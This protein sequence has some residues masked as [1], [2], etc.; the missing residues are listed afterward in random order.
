MKSVESRRKNTLGDRG[1]ALGSLMNL[2]RANIPTRGGN[3]NGSGTAPQPAV[4]RGADL[5]TLER[6]G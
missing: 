4:G 6:R 2:V 5:H 3:V 1:K